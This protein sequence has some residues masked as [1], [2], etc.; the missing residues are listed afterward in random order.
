[1]A[2]VGARDGRKRRAGLIRAERFN[3]CGGPRAR[4]AWTCRRSLARADEVVE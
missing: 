2:G 3:C 1:M 4:W